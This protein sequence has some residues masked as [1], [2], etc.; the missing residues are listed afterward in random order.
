MIGNTVGN[1]SG[2][3]KIYVMKA[4]PLFL[5]VLASISPLLITAAYGITYTVRTASGGVQTY[6][7]EP[8][9]GASDKFK[10]DP[11]MPYSVHNDVTQGSAALVAVA[12]AGGTAKDKTVSGDNYP[13]SLTDVGGKPG[14]FYNASNVKAE[15]VEHITAPVPYYLVRMTG[16]VGGQPETLYAGV[17]ES[18]QIIRP[19]PTSGKAQHAAQ[20][21]K[22]RKRHH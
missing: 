9:A 14:G 8:P 10:P 12:W 3:A 1:S 2:T 20:P 16:M 22:M 4:R 13:N 17:L 11:D 5:L 6:L 21:K 18:G 15:S 19:V 7:L